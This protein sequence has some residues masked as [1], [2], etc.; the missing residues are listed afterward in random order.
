MNVVP[1]NVV[2][3]VSSAESGAVTPLGER[4]T[5]AVA[6]AY[7]QSGAQQQSL[8][9]RANDGVTATNPASLNRLQIDVAHYTIEMAKMAGLV[10]HL[11]KGL[12]TIL[13]S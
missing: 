11:T 4:L 6:D 5:H 12:D 2:N 1:I 13:K 9:V 10:S 8:L 7:L 3:M